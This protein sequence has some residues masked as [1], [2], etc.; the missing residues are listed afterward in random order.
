M[1]NAF[2]TALPKTYLPKTANVKH[3]IS[4]EVFFSQSVSLDPKKAILTTATECFLAES[5]KTVF[6][7]SF[8]LL[9]H[10]A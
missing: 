8:Y 9:E 7:L 5:E 3:C 10:I 6:L 1:W 2:L 4:V